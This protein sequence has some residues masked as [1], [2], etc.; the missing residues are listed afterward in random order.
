MN[1]QGHF[2]K[3]PRLKKKLNYIFV[4]RKIWCIIWYAQILGAIFFGTF[5]ISTNRDGSDFR[6]K[7]ENKRKTPTKDFFLTFG[8][9]FAKS[10]KT[11]RK[12]FFFRFIWQKRFYTFLYVKIFSVYVC[13]NLL[14]VLYNQMNT[15][16]KNFLENSFNRF[17]HLSFYE[18]P[19]D[20]LD[21]DKR[22]QSGRCC[23][24]CLY[25]R[26]LEV[27]NESFG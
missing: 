26:H 19:L 2:L 1:F 8:Y 23:S 27:K 3:R 9:N 7:E 22:R 16:W 14:K 5:W 10:I 13:E 25:L 21:S 17:P 15:F 20:G 24:V 6:I 18:W 12:E 11:G 4:S